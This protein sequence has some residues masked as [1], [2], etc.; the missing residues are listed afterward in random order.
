M[1]HGSVSV[2]HV[3][4]AHVH[5]NVLHAYQLYHAYTRAFHVSNHAAVHVI[6]VFSDF[7]QLF[8]SV[9]LT[10]QV[11]VHVTVPVAQIAD[12]FHRVSCALYR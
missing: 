2:A 8:V 5:K 7:V 9:V 11:L 6:A 1:L 12:R 3:V 4:D 10:G